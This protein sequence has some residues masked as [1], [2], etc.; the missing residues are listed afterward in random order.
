MQGH[1]TYGEVVSSQPRR[2][3]ALVTEDISVCEVLEI[4]DVESGT[5]YMPRRRVFSAVG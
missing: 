5:I 2:L 1:T 3:S 4:G